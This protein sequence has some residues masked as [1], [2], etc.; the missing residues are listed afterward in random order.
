[1]TEVAPGDFSAWQG[2]ER[3]AEEE[4]R[5]P[6]VKNFIR[7][8]VQRKLIGLHTEEER[9]FAGFVHAIEEEV[10]EANREEVITNNILESLKYVLA[11]VF[12]SDSEEAK[13]V[14]MI[15]KRRKYAFGDNAFSIEIDVALG[16]SSYYLKI[17]SA[18]E[19]SSQDPL[20]FCLTDGK[21]T[22][23]F[24]PEIEFDLEDK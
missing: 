6:K 22:I 12:R 14:D 15:Q 13:I 19:H 17:I 18:Q 1:M 11:A 8:S 20:R 10:T 4:R 24:Y 16:G 5:E 3:E 23:D 9:E 21:D 2:A 7:K